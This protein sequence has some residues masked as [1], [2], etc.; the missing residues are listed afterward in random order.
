[1]GDVVEA[2]DRNLRL[3][4]ARLAEEFG[5]AR[6]TVSKRLALAGVEPD[7][8]RN[9]YPV[10]RLRD[11]CP[12]IL[13]TARDERG[14][15]DPKN[16]PPERRNAWYQ[17]EQRRLD[18]ETSAKQLIPAAQHEGELAEMAKELVQFLETLPDVL[19]RD[20]NLAPEQVES[21]RVAI[22]E[23]RQ[24]LYLK[25]IDRPADSAVA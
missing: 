4:I 12:A 11:A 2:G 23:Q 8:T 24:G 17:A 14:D 21:M 16:L 1:M 10:Y 25:L 22:D 5:M 9:S 3:S 13:G 7:G 15:F 19:E 20:R 6:E 18:F